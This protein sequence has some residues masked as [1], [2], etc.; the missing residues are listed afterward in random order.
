MFHARFEK[1]QIVS[2][3]VLHVELATSVMPAPFHFG[4]L[5]RVGT[6]VEPGVE[7]RMEITDAFRQRH[8]LVK[9]VAK[10][11]SINF[12]VKVLDFHPETLVKRHGPLAEKTAAGSPEMKRSKTHDL[13]QTRAEEI[14]HRGCDRRLSRAVKVNPQNEGLEDGLVDGRL[15]VPMLPEPTGEG[16]P[17][18]GDVAFT[19]DLANRHELSAPDRNGFA[20][21]LEIES[22]ELP[23]HFIPQRCHAQ[24]TFILE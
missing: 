21:L 13:S 23:G 4:N 8:K 9:N 17:E 10:D 5:H 22:S 3:L 20:L 6:F 19:F 2:L 1:A 14:T 12:G 7:L 11:V 24:G 15:G 16:H 18:L